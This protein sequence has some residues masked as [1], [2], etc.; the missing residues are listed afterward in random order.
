MGS[1]IFFLAFFLKKDVDKEV[2]TIG[3]SQRQI[4]L[5]NNSKIFL[6]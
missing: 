3:A 5:C 2:W 6:A 4:A 1:S